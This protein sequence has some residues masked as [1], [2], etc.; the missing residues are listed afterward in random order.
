MTRDAPPRP[1][2]TISERDT[3]DELH[4]YI[5][6]H[7]YPPSLREL[8]DNLSTTV[9]V[10]RRDLTALKTKGYVRQEATKARATAIEPP[11]R[12]NPAREHLVRLATTALRD[13]LDR[14]PGDRP[15]TLA[16]EDLAAVAVDAIAPAIGLTT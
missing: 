3:L 16:V 5:K 10:V 4:G 14:P 11:P 9:F 15:T 8:A 2:L 13:H 12:V 1:Q 6:A 7:G